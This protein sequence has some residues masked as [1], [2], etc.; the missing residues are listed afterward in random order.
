[1]IESYSLKD[2]WD[3]L[4]GPID[5]AFTFK[6][7]Q[8]KTFFFKVWIKMPPE[9]CFCFAQSIWLGQNPYIPK[10]FCWLCPRKKEKYYF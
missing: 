6:I 5:A 1:M 8:T 7:S 10:M 9:M 2:D 4:T 3:G